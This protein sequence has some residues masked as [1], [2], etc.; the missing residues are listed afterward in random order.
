VPLHEASADS[1]ADVLD[2]DRLDLAVLDERDDGSGAPARYVIEI[3]CEMAPVAAESPNLRP[4]SEG[5][6]NNAV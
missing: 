1:A 5:D 3:V 6:A 2:L 4:G